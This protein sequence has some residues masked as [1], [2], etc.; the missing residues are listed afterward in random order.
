MKITS[1]YGGTCNICGDHFDPGDEINWER[2]MEERLSASHWS[3]YEDDQKNAA[4]DIKPVQ[5]GVTITKAP[6]LSS[7]ESADVLSRMR[8]AEDIRLIGL[9]ATVRGVLN[10]VRD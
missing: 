1:K 8:R 6:L 2:G 5:K 4:S 3:C 7:E 9:Q 10:E